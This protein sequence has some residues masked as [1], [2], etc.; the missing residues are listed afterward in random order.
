MIILQEVTFSSF[1]VPHQLHSRHGYKYDIIMVT[2]VN[3]LIANHDTFAVDYA[4]S[5]NVAHRAE[6]STCADLPR[7][8]TESHFKDL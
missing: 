7:T 8:Y 1:C 6:V 4:L 5:V 2:H 3:L